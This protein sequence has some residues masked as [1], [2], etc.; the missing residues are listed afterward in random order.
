MSKSQYDME[1]AKAHITRKHIPF[2]DNNPD[3]M[4]MLAWLHKQA[5]ITQYIKGLIRADM[6]NS[7]PFRSLNG[8]QN[9]ND[10]A[11]TV[12]K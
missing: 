3:D 5:N 9:G 11:G 4:A 12:E 6:P 2:N 10:S 8:S 1:Y 7:R